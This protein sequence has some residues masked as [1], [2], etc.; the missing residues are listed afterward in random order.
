[1]DMSLVITANKSA[2]SEQLAEA[3]SAKLPAKEADRLQGFAELFFD[4][5]P[6][7]ELSGHDINDVIGMLK[8]SYSF[9]SS[10]KQKR[11]KVRV[12]NPSLE[13]EGWASKNTVITVHYNDVPFVID[14]VRM[15]LTNKGV[16]I[17]SIKNLVVNTQRDSKG[18]LLSLES[19]DHGV[20]DGDS[21]TQRELLVYIEVNLHG[22]S[23]DLN[24][25]SASIRKT[26]ADVN[27][28]NNHYGN[29]VD[30]LQLLQDSIPYSKNHH[31]REE[32]YETN[33]FIAWLMVNNFT[34]LGY[35]YYDF[36]G[37][38]TA[39]SVNSPVLKKSYGLLHK[40]EDINTYFPTD[41]CKLRDPDSPLLTFSKAPTRST[42]HRRAYPDHITV[43]AYNGDGKF[44]GVH[45]IVG[46]YTSQV[47]RAGVNRIPFIRQK[48]EKIY[49][50]ANLAPNS[51]NGK[52]L[53][54][55]L[56]TF[57]RD[58]L[59]QSN[60]KELEKTL[61]GVTQINER[62]H[63]RLF[64]RKSAD[65]R[66]VNAMAYIPR[67]QFSTNLRE[68]MIECLGSAVGAESHEFYSYYSESILSR[69][70][71]I[72]RLKDG[73]K[74]RWSESALE[75]QVQILASSWKDSLQKRLLSI[76][77]ED[78]GLR[79]TANIGNG[80]PN[81]Y[82]DDFSVDTAINDITV[83]NALSEDNPIELCFSKPEKGHSKEVHFKV[84]SHGNALPL[85][86][87]I[88]VLERMN[89][90]VIGEH[91]YKIVNGNTSV[92]LHDFVLHT[93]LNDDVELGDVRELFEQAFVQVWKRHIENDFFNGLVLTAKLAWR[94]VVVL[95]AYAAYMKQI[96]FPFSKRA[97]IKTLMTYP[98]VTSQ[99][100]S[101][102]YQR[103]DPSMQ[104]PGANKEYM[105]TLKSILSD[106]DA[107]SNLND[108]RI[109]RQYVALIEGT[110]RT[111]FFQ[112]VDGQAKDYVSFK[113]TP[114]TITDVPEP[115]PLYEI[116]VYSPRVE[117]VH[118]RGGKV[119]RGGLRWSD[120]GE[121]FRTEVL[122]LVKAQNVK[123]AV[124]VPNGAKGGFVA[125]RASISAG[126]DAFMKEGISCYQTFIRGLLDVTDNLEKGKVIAPK[127]VVRRDDDDPYLVVAA[128]KGTA[129]FSDIANEISKEYGHWLGDAF[130]S[131]GSQGYDHK[132]MGIT[133]KGAWVSVQRHFKEKGINVQ[134]EDFTV[135]GIG[136]M[137][138]DVFGNGML[139]SKHICLTAAF[140]H[141]HIFIDPNPN[142]AESYKERERLFTTQGTNWADYNTSLISK[143]GGVFSRSEKSIT[144]S[145]EMQACFDIRSSQMTPTDLINALLKAPVDLIWNG[146]IGTY[147]KCG[148]ESH[149][150]IGDKANDALRVNGS[151][152]RCK[153]FGEGGNLGLSQLGRIDYCMHGGS[154]NT[155]FIDNAAGVDCSDHEVNIKIL[156]SDIIASG[157]LSE[158]QRN[159]LLSSMT[160]TV[161]EMVL[162]NNY[163]QTQ[164]ISLAEREALSR[165]GEY[166]R[167]INSLEAS[168]RL[169]REL[170]FIPTD[171]ELLDRTADRHALTRPELSVLNCYVKVELKESLALDEIADDPYLA[172]W[173]E[174]AFPAKL[175]LKYK[176]NIHNHIQ[177]K[178]IIATQLA[179]DMV[180]NMG[181][182]FCHRMVESTGE[183][184]AAV[185][186][187]Y[188]AARDVFQ[189]DTFREEVE[190]LDYKVPAQDQLVLL[191]SMIRRVRRGTQWF[192]R[193]R[194][195]GMD[196]QKTVGIFKTAVADAIKGTPAVLNG[197]EKDA[198]E[199]KCQHF[200]DLG[201]NHELA[202][203]MAMPGHLFSGLGIAEAGL[204]SKQAIPDV[205]HMHHLLGDKLGFYWF[206]HAVTDVKVDNY[207]QSMARE[208]FI[209]D[210]D[211]VLRVMTVGLLRLAGKRFEHEEALQLWMH[212][213]PVLVTRWRDIA[214]ELQTTQA[215]DFAMFSVAMRE[216]TELAE[217]CQSCNRLSMG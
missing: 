80:F 90:K 66:F 12:F 110:V 203:I 178:E 179:N 133:A 67:D 99:L 214:H 182:T 23:K 101:L 174:K 165:I 35:A 191:S 210:I 28:V 41:H 121:D 193:N 16:T 65:D 119:A 20:K 53:R 42:I 1:M 127:N 33:Q 64:M 14:S 170:E 69:T 150:D 4:H 142:P 27:L 44:I 164:S 75:E 8:D 153:V 159:R 95:R 100:V 122:G 207:W 107:I 200:E 212:E 71:M 184:E 36:S 189:F 141:M 47:Y 199:K 94:D 206:A 17:K 29:I 162:K 72:F 198:W 62:N 130:A 10:Y 19:S 48:V 155:D 145:P 172:S 195:E 161:S 177:R 40:E 171:Q 209:N 109:L 68:E 118:L 126:R 2:F 34:F 139:M 175:L 76:Y 180:D 157:G 24:S 197:P 111:N 115:R 77:G 143:G 18:E 112:Q 32:I 56:E 78:E 208:A 13:K 187:A 81:S 39:K 15:A 73:A 132:G 57:P 91:P 123:N 192:L 45:H 140:N 173:V 186:K 213:Y 26:I 169:N 38:K 51:Y 136:D 215:S 188:V 120:R 74:K 88:P 144:I 89:L 9:L 86:D 167:L 152:L 55:A 160:D 108:D 104:K 205:V 58:E 50:E 117:G 128:D 54:Q 137:A 96:T 149:A 5:Y 30:E 202:N 7:A 217:V 185:A 204:Q 158:P 93:Q 176:R 87:V 156:L 102:F 151:Q 49:K 31:S 84:F 98:N 113:L 25:I 70:Y 114:Q 103:F 190:K 183:S 168:G 146:G 61:L 63:V 3:I 211:K 106:L 105:Q 59:F 148:S 97:I 11:A 147:V 46:L 201:L 116:F 163:F 92:W 22:K 79:L 21:K 138:G 181:I 216:L 129:T 6:I 124:I 85:S 52:V 125:K 166:R 131:G 154:C 196:L 83:I 60:V 134:K 43:Q 37:K 82:Q 194:H 135:V